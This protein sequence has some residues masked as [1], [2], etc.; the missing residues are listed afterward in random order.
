MKKILLI[1]LYIPI[2]LIGQQDSTLPYKTIHLKRVAP[3]PIDTTNLKNKK[4]ILLFSDQNAP[5]LT[6]I[7]GGKN[8]GNI[9]LN[10]LQALSEVQI[11]DYPFTDTAKYIVISFGLSLSH[12]TNII[13]KKAR[14]H[15]RTIQQCT[16]LSTKG[17]TLTGEMKNKLTSLIVG[18]HIM[19]SE[20]I[21]REKGKRKKLTAVGVASLNIIQ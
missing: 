5:R 8:G 20:V 19:V 1:L 12:N 6:I 15:S 14:G 10:E 21:Y 7:I 11:E 3:T 18:D 2:L 13:D 16:Y 9:T 4:N 17:H